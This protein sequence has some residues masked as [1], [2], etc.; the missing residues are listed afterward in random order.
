MSRLGGRPTRAGGRTKSLVNGVPRLATVI[1]LLLT[2]CGQAPGLHGAQAQTRAAAAGVR[3]ASFSEIP[4]TGRIGALNREMIG[5]L[6][7]APADAP[8]PGTRGASAGPGEQTRLQPLYL[9]YVRTV[10]GVR[11][12]AGGDPGSNPLGLCPVSG[13]VRGW[14]SFGAPRYA[15][16]Y[17]P[18]AGM[19][20]MAPAGAPILAPFS[21]FALATPNALGGNA[22]EVFGPFG[23]VYNAHLSRY[24]RLGRVAMGAVIGYVG[25]TGDARGGPT[26]DHF[27]WHP[28][29][30]PA[31]PWISPYG[32][33]EI[34]GAIDPFPYLREACR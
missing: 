28:N 31:H 34:H 21:G 16:G 22:V 5:E 4:G 23:F 10:N 9:R 33:A 8:A 30:M 17:H 26:H 13:P 7:D 3:F 14:D 32:Y 6:G 2:A 27:E 20:I 25:N 18:H 15:G 24:G 19:D 29:A 12:S 1:A 11:Q